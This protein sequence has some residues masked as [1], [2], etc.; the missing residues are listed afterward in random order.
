[1]L[2]FVLMV[3]N[4]DLMVCWK[5]SWTIWSHKRRFI[6]NNGQL[7][8]VY[9]ECILPEQSKMLYLWATLQEVCLLSL[10][11]NTRHFA[12]LSWL[13]QRESVHLVFWRHPVGTPTGDQTSCGGGVPLFL[14][15]IRVQRS[16]SW[17]CRFVRMY[18]Q[19]YCDASHFARRYCSIYTES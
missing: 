12:Q 15:V 2:S 14:S 10:G 11:C 7:Q 9:L 6:R 19:S 13:A 1:M 8:S 5:W 18:S 17:Y 16:R 4:C 3:M